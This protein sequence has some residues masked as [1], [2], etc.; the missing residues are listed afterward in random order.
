MARYAQD[1][2]VS[3]EKSK[4][5]I[6]KIIQRYGATGFVSAWKQ[7]KA[8]IMFEMRDRRLRFNLPLPD[9]NEKR[10]THTP[11][12]DL[13][14]HPMDVQKHWEQACRQSWRAL[15]LCIKAKLESVEAGIVE[16]DEEF[17]PYIVMAN[18]S[19]VAEYI[20]PQL[21]GICGVDRMLPLLPGPAN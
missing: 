11:G 1:T 19:T 3:V 4:A 6:E 16:F 7:G 18:G 17:M 2:S 13:E 14:R 10:F 15:L 5:E 8:S 12:K 9:R 20:M 21:P